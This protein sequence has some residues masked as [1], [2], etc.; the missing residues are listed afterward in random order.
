MDIYDLDFCYTLLSKCIIGGF[1]IA[2]IPLMF[3]VGVHGILKIFK[4]AERG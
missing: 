1:L 4:L 2:C 3:G